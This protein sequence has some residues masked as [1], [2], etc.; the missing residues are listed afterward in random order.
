MSF[1][2]DDAPTHKEQGV[3]YKKARDG[4][5]YRLKKVRQ[6]TRDEQAKRIKG[7]VAL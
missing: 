6:N 5:L 3:V 1:K 4:H 7:V 2:Q